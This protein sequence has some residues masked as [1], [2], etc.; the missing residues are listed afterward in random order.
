MVAADVESIVKSPLSVSQ[1]RRRRIGLATVLGFVV[2]GA[3][4]GVVAAQSQGASPG[5]A[6]RPVAVPEAA[7]HLAFATFTGPSNVYSPYY[8]WDARFGLNV[9]IYRRG[10]H[11]AE[12]HGVMQSAGTE[13]F[14]TRI[15]VG[16]AG[17][18]MR[19]AYRR[20]HSAT[21]SFR[22]GIAHLSAHLTR[23]LDEKTADERR[24]GASIPDVEDPSEYNV[25]FL[26]GTRRF[27]NA[28]FAPAIRVGVAPLNLRL[29]G[30]VRG[31][32][33]RPI[34]AGT[35]WTLVRSG[36]RAIAV[37]TEHEIGANPVN[38]VTLAWDTRTADRT[39]SWRVFLSVSPGRG[40]QVSPDLGAV[41]DGVAVGFR[42]S[43]D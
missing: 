8:S 28:R 43:V 11:A 21:T 23:D 37:E 24:R 34:Y 26:E 32:H 22:A 3:V 16:G 17:Y 15:G 41:R 42:V 19:I 13:N 25:G 2:V 9:V 29:D 27:P 20:D 7:F 35:A 31:P 5:P 6:D 40:L 33:R 30:R 1:M 10:K 18:L 4:P 38:R 36:S 39:R 14:G 12:F